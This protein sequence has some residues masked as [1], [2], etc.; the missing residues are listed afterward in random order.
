LLRRLRVALVCPWSI[1][2][3][4]E[5]HRLVP[6]F[7]TTT[8]SLF[9]FTLDIM[10]PDSTWLGKQTLDA[11]HRLL[12][13]VIRSNS[14]H[15][16]RFGTYTCL[17]PASVLR[18][19]VPPSVGICC[20]VVPAQ[21]LGACLA[22]NER[23]HPDVSSQRHT[24]FLERLSSLWSLHLHVGNNT[25]AEDLHNLVVALLPQLRVLLINGCALFAAC[26]CSHTVTLFDA[27][28]QSNQQL[29]HRP[30]VQ[31]CLK[32]TVPQPSPGRDLFFRGL[33]ALCVRGLRQ[34]ELRLIGCLG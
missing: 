25:K 8:S 26:E 4:F 7:A 12:E 31:T 22:D 33:E 6:L 32:I 5:L 27:I 29:D 2:N 11:L 14:I 16:V 23:L 9:D 34:L 24:Q 13:V 20:L 30:L 15:S 28:L 10:G 17:Q 1:A 18:V 19:D 3:G 21:A